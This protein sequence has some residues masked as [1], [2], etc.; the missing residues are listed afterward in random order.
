MTEPYTDEIDRLPDQQDLADENLPQQ[1]STATKGVFAV[2]AG[3][4]GLTGIALIVSALAL[5][6]AMTT[7]ISVHFFAALLGLFIAACMGGLGVILILTSLFG[8]VAAKIFKTKKAGTILIAAILIFVAVNVFDI[9][10]PRSGISNPFAH[11]GEADAEP[12]YEVEPADYIVE[13]TDDTGCMR[14]STMHCERQVIEGP[15]GQIMEEH[16]LFDEVVDGTTVH[17]ESHTT[18]YEDG[19]MSA[20]RSFRNDERNEVWTTWYA[21]GQTSSQSHYVNGSL[22]GVERNWTEEGIEITSD[23][24]ATTNEER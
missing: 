8:W 22:V 20:K 24:G 4:S 23:R 3:S 15:N 11:M 1:D 9:G 5:A 10:F 14:P 6:G 17:A 12:A 19:Q 2:L 21:N 13:S 18:W 7:Q 16:V